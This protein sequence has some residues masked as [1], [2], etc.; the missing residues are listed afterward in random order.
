[1][2]E[3]EDMARALEEDMIKMIIVSLLDHKPSLYW[4]FTQ[5]DKEKSGFVGVEEW[6]TGLK[7]V[8]QLDLPFP[9]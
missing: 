6:S 3:Q 7:T 8:L 2:S 1:M 5:V 4:Y 9:A